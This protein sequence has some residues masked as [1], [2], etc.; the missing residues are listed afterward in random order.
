MRAKI[1]AL[2]VA[3]IAC[4]PTLAQPQDAR[5]GQPGW[6]ADANGC[7]AWNA[8]PEPNET[9]TWSG[10]CPNGY[11]TGSGVLEWFVNGVPGGRHQGEYR[12]GRQNGPGIYEH[13]TGFYDGEWLDGE[14]HGPGFYIWANGDEYR[15]EFRHGR[16]DGRGVYDWLNGDRYEGAWRD[17]LPNG[18]GTFRRD[19]GLILTGEWVNGSHPAC[20]NCLRPVQR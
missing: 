7:R 19:N 20:V 14:M 18:L 17:G 11:A 4:T 1:L 8:N 10:P 15:G 5:P 9:I 16:R 13:R 12:D 6:I 2:V 3:M